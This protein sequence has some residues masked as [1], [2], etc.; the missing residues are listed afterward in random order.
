MTRTQTHTTFS[1]RVSAQVKDLT[2]P[3]VS[4]LDGPELNKKI[5]AQFD[6]EIKRNRR[7]TLYYPDYQVS[8]LFSEQFDRELKRNRRVTLYCPDYHV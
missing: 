8:A 6:R 7:V 3:S 2:A 4:E 1:S 5:I